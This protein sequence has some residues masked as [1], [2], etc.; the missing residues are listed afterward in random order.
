MFG[1]FGQGFDFLLHEGEVSLG[2][3]LEPRQARFA[4]EL[5]RGSL[6][7][8]GVGDHFGVFSEIVPRYHAKV[9]RVAGFQ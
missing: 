5:D 3:F 7:D 4:T 2:I 9:E 1:L 6:V 8:M